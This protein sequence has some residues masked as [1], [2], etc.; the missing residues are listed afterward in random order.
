MANRKR[1]RKINNNRAGKLCISMILLAFVAAMSIQIVKVYQK[2]QEYAAK[3]ELLEQQLLD[4]TNRQDEL[5]DYEQYTQS[6]QYIED[7]AKSKLGLL[8][9][10]EIV[11]REQD[12]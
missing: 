2:D 10:N 8:Y 5:E 7:M 4:E 6:Q 12:E 9:D 11:F 3:Q 1:K